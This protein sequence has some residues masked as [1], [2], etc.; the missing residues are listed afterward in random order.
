MWLNER[1]IERKTFCDEMVGVYSLMTKK[2]EI[3]INT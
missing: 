2:I 1:S 3:I